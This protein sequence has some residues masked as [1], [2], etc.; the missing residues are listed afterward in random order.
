MGRGIR[1]QRVRWSP[2]ASG[3][4]EA[5]GGRVVIARKLY[6]SE[7][8]KL[9]AEQAAGVVLTDGGTTSHV[10]I[11]ARSLKIPLV[12]VQCPELMHLPESATVL[13]DGETG[14]AYVNPSKEIV[15]RFE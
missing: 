12:E 14:N 15:D 9:S 13:M 6:P 5:V 2:A 3:G 8:L 4:A 11:I 1:S 7:L 10:A